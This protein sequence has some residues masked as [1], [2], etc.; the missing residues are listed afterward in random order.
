MAH[1]DH[2]ERLRK[3]RNDGIARHSHRRHEYAA[4]MRR[5]CAQQDR[6]KTARVS[7][8]CLG[9]ASDQGE[10]RNAD[11]NDHAVRGKQITKCA[12]IQYTARRP[13]PRAAPSAAARPTCTE[14]TLLA[15]AT[16]TLADGNAGGPPVPTTRCVVS[17]RA[18]VLRKRC[19]VSTVAPPYIRRGATSMHDDELLDPTAVDT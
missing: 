8:P 6:V 15:R 14:Q 13:S 3:F 7:G 12:A 17:H 2:A 1:S 18:V 10:Q 19:G 9:D 11:S 5:N 16:Q 4:W